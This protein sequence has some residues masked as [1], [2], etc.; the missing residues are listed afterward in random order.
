MPK[1][2]GLSLIELIVFIIVISVGLVGIL[3]VMNVSV[4]GSADPMLRKQAIALAEGILEEVLTKSYTDIP[5][6][7]V[8]PCPNRAFYVGVDD[9]NCFSGTPATAVI[10]GATTLGGAP[11][12]LVGYT[13]IVVVAPVVINGQNMK[14]I[15][16][17]VTGGGE[18]IE[19][20]GYRADI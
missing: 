11:T 15:K 3:S 10:D 6:A 4:R 12:G 13:G 1:Q 2:S 7:D 9:Y 14:Q 20:R 5:V 16:V 8:A 19:L 17:T 18:T